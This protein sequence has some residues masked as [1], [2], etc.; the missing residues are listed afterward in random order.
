VKNPQGRDGADRTASNNAASTS[1]QIAAPTINLPKGGGGIKGI[2][3]KFA[4]NP[5]TGTGSMMVPIATSPSRSGFGPQLSLSYDSGADNGPFGFG[6]QLSLPSITRKTDKGLPQYQDADES[7]V[8]LISGAEDLV[9]EFEKDASGNWILHDGK[10]IV[11]DKPRTVDGITYRIRR[12]RPRIEGLLARIERWSNTADPFDVHWRSISK[13][14]ILTLYGRNGNSRIA[15]PEN[16]TYIFS[17]LI[18][19][20]RDDKGNAILYEYKPEDGRGVVLTKV[21]ERNRGNINDVRRTA[22]RYL[23]R[24][25]YGNRTSLLD[26]YGRRPPFLTVAQTQSAGWMFEVVLDYDEHDRNVPTPLEAKEW[27]FRNDPFSTYRAGFEVRTTRLCQRVLMFHHIPDLSSSAQGYEGLVRSTD[28]DYSYERN[29]MEAR[30]PIYSFLMSVKQSGY[31]KE[32]SGYMKHSM[33]PVE[34]EYIQP[35]VQET[36][37]EVDAESLEN[38]PVGVDGTNYQWTDLHGEGI[39]GILTEQG[40]AWYFK[41]NLSALGIKLVKFSSLEVVA[42]KPNVSIAGG[43]AQFMDLAGDGQPDLAVLDG[44]IPGLYE[45]DAEEGWQNFRPFS[46]RLSHDTRDPNTRFVDLDGD[47]HIDVLITEED[48]IVWHASLAEDG[49]GPARRVVN[50]WDE[51]EGPRLVFADGAESVYLADLNGDNLTDLVRIRNGE[52][53]YWPNLGYGR[54]G[55]KITMDQ[56]PIWDQPDVFDYKRIRLADIDGTGAAD[57]IYLH[58]DGVR[59]YFNQSGNSWSKPQVLGLFPRVDDLVSIALADLLGNGT[60]CL[61][62]SSPLP[63]DTHRPMRYVKL[64]GEHKPHLLVKTVNNLGA[65]THV[66]YAPSCKF[67]LQDKQNGKPWITRLPFPVHVV[68]RVE[69]YDRISRNRFVSR[70]RYHHGYFDA[71]EREFRGFGM[72]E[73]IDTEEIGTIGPGMAHLGDTNLDAASFVPPAVTK[74]WFHTGAYIDSEHVS[75]FYAGFRNEDD[76][77]EYYREPGMTDVQARKLLLDDTILPD[78]MTYEE[79]RE[80]CRA[81]KGTMLRQEIYAQDSSL[82]GTHPYVVTEQNF[83]VRR[84][85]PADGNRHAVFFVHPRE[86]IGYHYERNP[87]DPRIAHSLNFEVDEFGNVLKSAA[88]AYGRRQND[89][90]L[91]SAD[92]AKQAEIHITYEENRVTNAV[93]AEDDHYLPLPCE[94]RS[95]ELTGLNLTSQRKRFGLEQLGTAGASALPIEYQEKP[96]SATIQKR[97]IGHL[98]ILYRQSDFVEPLPLGRLESLAVPFESYKL[99]FTAGLLNQVYTRNGQL[100]LSSPADVLQGGGTA[101]GGYVDLDGNGHW[102]IASGRMH[103]SPNTSDVA[104][105]ELAYARQHFFLPHRYRNPFHTDA[106]STESV[107][108]YDRYDLLMVE[109]RDALDNRVTVEN[110]DYRVLQPSLVVDT[111]RNRTEVAFDTLG[112]VVGTAVMGK[113]SEMQGDLLDSSFQQDLTQAQINTFFASPREPGPNPDES[114][115]TQIVHDLLSKATTR[116]V[117]DLDRFMTIGE[118]SCAA[119][120]GR[121][122]HVSDLQSGQRTKIQVTIS[123]SDGFG[124]EIQKKIQAEPGPVP[125]RDANGNI[126]VGPDGRPIMTSNDVRPR[127]VGSGWTIYNNKGKP[128]RQYEPFFTDQHRFEFDARIGVSPVF[129]YDP[130]ER[131]V[132]TLYPN[133][134]WEKVIFDAWRKEMWDVNDTV[135]IADPKSDSDMGYIFS[136]LT[137][138]DYMPTWHALRTDSTHITAFATHYPNSIEQA[139]E[140]QAAMKTE[141]HAATRTLVYADSIGQTFLTMAHNKFKRNGALVEEKYATRVLFD[142]EG[143]QREVIDGNHHVVMRYDYDMLGTRIHQASMEAGERW[144]LS[145]VAGN[146]IRSWDS[147]GHNVRTH[148]DV[149]R[150]PLQLFVRGTD[151]VQSDRRT[152]GADLEVSRTV[153]GEGQSNDVARNL[154]TKVFQTLDSAGIITNGGINPV[155]NQEESYD[156][157][158][159]LLRSYRTVA[160]DYTKIYDWNADTVEASWETFSASTNYD[161]LNRHVTATSPDGSI[162]QP[163]FNEAN[164][165]DKVDVLLS[166]VGNPRRFVT[167]VDYN[168]K[169][170]RVRI[171]YGNRI[172]TT[173]DYDPLTFRLAHLITLRGT[174]KLQ[175]LSYTYDPAGNITHIQD[176]AQQIIYFNNQVVEPHNDYAYDAVYRLIEARGREHI[177]QVAQ[178]ESSWNDEF[179]VKRQHPQTSQ[180]MRPYTERYEYDAAG[181][182]E[183]MRHTADPF[184]LHQNGSWTRTY[185]YSEASL[186]E[187]GKQNNRVSHTIVGRVAG[188]PPQETY[189][190]DNHGNMLRMSHL[191]QMN[192]DFKDQLQHVNLAGGGQAYYVYDTGGQR[193]RKVVEKNGGTLIEERIYF[194]GFEIFRVRNG[195]GSTSLERETLHIVDDKQRIAVIETRTHGNDGSSA[196]LTRYQFGNHL[197][198][199]ALEMDETAQ[200]ISYEE[201]YPY[202]GTSYQAGR[203]EAEVRLKRYRYIGM[204]R[205]EESGLNYHGARYYATWFARWIN[206]DPTGITGGLN[207]FLY[208]NASP[209]VFFDPTGNEPRSVTFELPAEFHQKW[210]KTQTLRLSGSRR[211]KKSTERRERSPAGRRDGKEGGFGSKTSKATQLSTARVTEEGGEGDGGG[212][213]EPSDKGTN[214]DAVP[215]KSG[216]GA[217]TEAEPSAGT[218]LKNSSGT[219][220]SSNDKSGQGSGAESGDGGGSDSGSRQDGWFHAPTWLRVALILGLIITALISITSFIQSV[221]AGWRTAGITG[222]FQAAATNAATRAAGV[223]GGAGLADYLSASSDIAQDIGN[224]VLSGHGELRAGPGPTVPEGTWVTV[225]AELGQDI[226]YGLGNFIELGQP[227]VD[228]FTKTYGPGD[229]LPNLFL[230]P[231]GNMPIAGNPV[232]VTEVTSI[233]DLLSPNMGNVDWAACLRDDRGNFIFGIWGPVRK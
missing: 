184:L 183:V 112:F 78:G 61:V 232:T 42:L 195:T 90:D 214:K 87:D 123:Y 19:E 190:Y 13:D 179:R 209:V 105:Q 8:F 72:V 44:P 84:L 104:G 213:G 131:A 215:G 110:N 98:R 137:D 224:T 38:V 64:M 155:T 228:S 130:V 34:F 122:T 198:S 149:L 132:A 220:A 28:F 48:A 156:F 203:S 1:F 142:I 229:T 63:G 200:I 121:E 73:Q 225:H 154:R 55:A 39:P 168:A 117:Y 230:H 88:V 81:L 140:K 100:L 6:W 115:A 141:V 21:H 188:T 74:T 153:Y 59:L 47:G 79:A 25:K 32:G 148:Y 23:K 65:E 211:H 189:L 82:K 164:L 206:A 43:T 210:G 37:E 111:N 134:T 113:A 180:A 109:S 36:I 167:D 52:V 24:I 223:G 101:R 150:R 97:L 2:G 96:T 139:N 204:E 219:T 91:V 66:G 71:E 199:A 93:E 170:Q 35:V 165:L 212:L 5:V 7:D 146:S 181:N 138:T 46:S 173:Y 85:Q 75:N 145:D 51:E 69:T 17:W 22:N 40:G 31:K 30:N 144:M 218:G 207:L 143:N 192:W 18:C 176:D 99:A 124:R 186:L 197:G 208:S 108:T 15:D 118:P 233:G 12:Y 166:G 14:N 171:A 158:G 27:A 3:E 62:W 83:T 56:S 20:S 76:V 53:C 201:Y 10:P 116:V 127:W 94:G 193:V 45:H 163:T 70:F 80:A 58:R 119:T 174:E 136:R 26:Q 50:A 157:K 177:G 95:Y 172:V 169:G 41:R 152:L 33:P 16:A 194:G 162:Y 68:E 9:P 11:Y 147:R 227:A 175:N 151:A 202:G 67:Y 54:F 129:F 217:S 196:Q 107:I 103:F 216:K 187:P 106:V 77:G 57:I 221:I 231:P 226:S 125:Q 92:Q 102:W 160:N 4:A 60:A 89:P 135:L 86:S 222:A 126:I 128:V 182:F 161:A 114:V 49:F 191:P 185:A 178:P 133:H 159:N 29:P 205:D 120:I